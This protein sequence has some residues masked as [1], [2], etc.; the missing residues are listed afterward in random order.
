MASSEANRPTGALV[1]AELALGRWRTKTRRGTIAQ[2]AFDEDAVTLAAR[3]GLGVLERHPDVRPTALVIA[4][5]SAP[6]PEPGIAPFLCEILDLQAT[7]DRPGADVFELGGTVSAGLTAISLGLTK[8][9]QGGPVLV[10]AA[11][12]RRDVTGRPLGAGAVALLIAEAGEAGGLAAIGHGSELFLDRWQHRADPGVHVGDRSLDRFSPGRGFAEGL[13]VERTLFS[14]AEGP[15]TERTGFPGV[16]AS[17]VGLLAAE[18]NE[19]ESVNLV[20][21]AGG[22]SRAVEFTAGPGFA[23]VAERAKTEMAGGLDG[24][25]PEDPDESAFDPYRSDAIARRERAQTY[26]LE[27]ARDPDTDEIFF[28]PPPAASSS[29]LEVLRLNRTGTVVTFARDHVFPMG[30]PLS[31]SVVDLDG[32]GRFYG[33]V[34]DGLEV[35]IGDSVELV[36]RRLH[37]GGGVPNYFWK[38]QPKESS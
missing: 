2:A 6:L 31:M 7:D 34:V 3:C 5:L 16:A 13:P 37:Q 26:R 23:G 21:S 36:L 19:G 1:D 35:E 33:Q 38:V 24:E 14:H 28:P 25:R 22:V 29:G 17:F 10:V 12:D 9:N 32:G 27:A 4:T 30:S 20:S 18:I 8:V 15:T 11:D